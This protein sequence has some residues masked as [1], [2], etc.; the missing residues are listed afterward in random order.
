[1]IWT[2]NVMIRSLV[3]HQVMWLP[4]VESAYY[5]GNGLVLAEGSHR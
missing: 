3:N 2:L 4:V 1:M 5:E